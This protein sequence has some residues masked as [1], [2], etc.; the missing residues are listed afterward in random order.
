MGSDGWR[1]RVRRLR[2][3]FHSLSAREAGEAS[4]LASLPLLS[5]PLTVAS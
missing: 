2:N 1:A 3:T 5:K 4:S